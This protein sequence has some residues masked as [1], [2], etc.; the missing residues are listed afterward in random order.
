[1]LHPVLLV[2]ALILGV[3]ARVAN[4]PELFV[5]AVVLLATAW[6]STCLLDHLRRKQNEKNPI[7][8]VTASVAGHRMET[9]RSRYTTS[10]TF[11]L[12]FKPE[13]G[14]EALEFEVPEKDYQDFGSGDK[15]PLRY[16]T[17]EY[18]SFCARDLSEVT[19]LA[20]IP[21]EYDSVPADPD[22]ASAEPSSALAAEQATP[23]EDNGILTHELDE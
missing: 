8:T 20:P 4:R 7:T 18:I 5:F 6:L 2:A 14:G 13:D 22:E 9:H 16:R 11:Y 23:D 19:P 17:W 21:E 3:A 15:G 12:T 10:H 1:M